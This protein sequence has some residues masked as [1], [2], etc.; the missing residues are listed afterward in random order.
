MGQG[1]SLRLH[2]FSDY[3]GLSR[4]AVRGTADSTRV[5]MLQ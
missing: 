5:A 3:S 4:L 1:A 2:D